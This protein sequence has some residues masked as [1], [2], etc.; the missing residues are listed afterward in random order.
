M[1]IWDTLQTLERVHNAAG[2]LTEI[3]GHL[4]TFQRA[5]SFNPR[6]S[7]DWD[8]LGNRD[9]QLRAIVR[10]LRRVR[11]TTRRLTRATGH[12]P[13]ESRALSRLFRAWADAYAA[14]GRDA[15]QTDKAQYAYLVAQMQWADRWETENIHALQARKR[16][17]HQRRFYL[18]QRDLF[19]DLENIA[20]RCVQHWPNTAQQAQALTYMLDF[21][22]IKNL[23]RSIAND[24]GRAR[25]RVSR[26]QGDLRTAQRELR[27]WLNWS[28]NRRTVERDVQSGRA[29]K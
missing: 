5:A 11:R 17:T 22:T 4:R 10:V 7:D 8:I 15:R 14:H 26:W 25:S 13:N 3:R 18:M 24:Y 20:R 2:Q 16:L 1:S 21:E 27:A 28:R 12:A 29:R 19:A 9:S 23:S 6:S